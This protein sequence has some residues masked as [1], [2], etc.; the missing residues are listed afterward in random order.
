MLRAV[1]TSANFPLTVLRTIKGSNMSNNVRSTR[2]RLK[3]YDRYVRQ[4]K[5]EGYAR[6]VRHG[7]KGTNSNDRGKDNIPFITRLFGRRKRY[8]DARGKKGSR[9]RQMSNGRV[10]IT[11]RVFRMVRR[12]NVTTVRHRARRRLAHR[13]GRMKLILGHYVRLLFR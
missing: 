1:I 6:R 4:G 8:H 11:F 3:R 12:I 2:R 7:R 13:Y 9:S 10:L 5:E